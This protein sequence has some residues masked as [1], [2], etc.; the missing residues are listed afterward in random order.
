MHIHK[1]TYLQGNQVRFHKI[2]ELGYKI[3]CKVTTLK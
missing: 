2:I 1:Q 3:Q